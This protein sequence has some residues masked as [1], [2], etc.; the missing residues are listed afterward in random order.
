MGVRGGGAAEKE[1]RN[2]TTSLIVV[3]ASQEVHLPAD[4]FAL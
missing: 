3:N 2:S 1:K 4:E